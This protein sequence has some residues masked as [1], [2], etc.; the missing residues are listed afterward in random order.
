MQIPIL[1][2]NIMNWIKVC[3]LKRIFSCWCPCACTCSC[4]YVAYCKPL[5]FSSIQITVFNG[6][7]ANYNSDNHAIKLIYF[8]FS[9]SHLLKTVKV[10]WKVTERITVIVNEWMTAWDI[11]EL[12]D[13]KCTCI[14]S[15][16]SQVRTVWGSSDD[17][18]M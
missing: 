6:I 17:P 9:I 16:T 1:H 13:L 3:Q 14:S 12:K 15:V 2:D 4:R 11:K 8:C 10:I 18:A 5:T 7:D